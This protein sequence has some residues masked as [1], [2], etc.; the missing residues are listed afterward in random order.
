M[1]SVFKNDI[2]G[3][4]SKDMR[5][6]PKNIGKNIYMYKQEEIRTAHCSFSSSYFLIMS[7]N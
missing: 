7:V 5:N 1:H 2:K 3:K 6:S 4:D